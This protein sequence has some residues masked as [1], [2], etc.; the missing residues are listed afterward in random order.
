MVKIKLKIIKTEA[1][2]LKSYYEIMLDI[3]TIGHHYS[4]TIISF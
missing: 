1:K 2:G 3:F 4:A